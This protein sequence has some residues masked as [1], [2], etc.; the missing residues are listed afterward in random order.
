MKLIGLEKYVLRIETLNSEE[1]KSKINEL[2]NE[3]ENLSE[4]IKKNI[5]I[6]QNESKRNVSLTKEYLWD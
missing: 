1:L 4:K 2:W 3:R 6:M 5:K